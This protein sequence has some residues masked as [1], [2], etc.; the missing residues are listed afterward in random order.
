MGSHEIF[1]SNSL[2]KASGFCVDRVGNI[3]SN[4]SSIEFNLYL[5]GVPYISSSVAI[6]CL[7]LNLVFT[8]C[9]LADIVRIIIEKCMQLPLQ[10]FA[11]NY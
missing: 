11:V 9:A 6:P 5:S 7:R 3:G 8:S 2:K 10:S 4:R 1:L